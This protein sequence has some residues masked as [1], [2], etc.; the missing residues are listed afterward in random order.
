M[1]PDNSKLTT[2]LFSIHKAMQQMF[3][4]LTCTNSYQINDGTIII[5]TFF[6][7]HFNRLHVINEA[8]HLFNYDNLNQILFPIYFSLTF[9]NRALA[10][11]QKFFGLK[12][13]H[14]NSFSAFWRKY[15]RIFAFSNKFLQSCFCKSLLLVLLYVHDISKK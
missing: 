6:I 7:R 1:H 13:L 14:F 15:V 4:K 5:F 2:V 10:S 9:W 11:V 8:V 3:E 12:F